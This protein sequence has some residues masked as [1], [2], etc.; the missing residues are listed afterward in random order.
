MGTIFHAHAAIGEP[1]CEASPPAHD[2]R[3]TVLRR[4]AE[5]RPPGAAFAGLLLTTVD[6]VSRSFLTWGPLVYSL[7]TASSR[8]QKFVS[9]IL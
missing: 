9:I 2:R 7:I 3:R 5:L 8:C 1:S 4:A 6:P